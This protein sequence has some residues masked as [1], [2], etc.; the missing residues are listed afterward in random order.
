MFWFRVE[1]DEKGK[2]V[3]CQQVA[4][5]AD[6]QTGGVFFFRA[7]SGK[8]AAERA[9]REYHRLRMAARRE[10]YA[11]EG[12]CKCGRSRHAESESDR[13]FV[14]CPACRAINKPQH[15]RAEL[16]R[17]GIE[18]AP[19]PTKADHFVARRNEEKLEVL[20]RV[21][22]EFRRNTMRNFGLWLES[23]I[24]EL[25]PKTDSKPKLRAV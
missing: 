23:A 24:A 5:A 10:K 20:K 21:R 16:R 12:R 9:Y 19:G 11:A 7:T 1:L 18:V 14:T 17:K 13:A 25:E 4:K 8:L 2:V 3:S 6:L 15:K 22:E